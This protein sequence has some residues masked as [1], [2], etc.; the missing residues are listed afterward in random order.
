MVEGSW[1]AEF[2]K[3]LEPLADEEVI[4]HN[5]VNAFYGTDLEDRLHR[6][7][8]GHLVIA[9]VAMNSVVETTGRHAADVGWLVTVAEDACSSADSDLHRAALVNMA[10]LG[11][12]GS[13]AAIVSAGFRPMHE[14]FA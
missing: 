5:R 14:G 13:V 3:G 2:H 9:G 4:T 7:G 1:G 10:L 12:V 6:M 8:I 11:E